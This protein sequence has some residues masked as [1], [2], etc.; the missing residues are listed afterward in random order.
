MQAKEGRFTVLLVVMALS[1]GLLFSSTT[2]LYNDQQEVIAQKQLQRSPPSLP[3]V[4]TI[5]NTSMSVPA[6]SASIN[7]QSM[8][9]QIVVALPLRDDGKI[10]TGT[11]TFTASKP[12]E[13]EVEHKYNPKVIPDA[14]HGAPYNGIWIDN[15]TRIALSTMTTFSNTPVIITNTPI[16]TGSLVFAGS[17]L[18][19]HKTDGIPFTVTYTI[20]AVAKPLTQK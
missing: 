6:P 11:V 20:D 15:T 2:I 9:H 3:D 13:I 5:Q 8:P 18:V 12:I 16:S 14:R 17:A 1:T 10:W 7:K 19:F 4:V